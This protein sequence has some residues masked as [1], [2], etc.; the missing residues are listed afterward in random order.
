A[1]D[2]AEA[3]FTAGKKER[4]DVHD[5][6]RFRS[7]LLEE[8]RRVVARTRTLHARPPRENPSADAHAYRDAKACRYAGSSPHAC[9]A[10]RA[11]SWNRR[12]GNVG[13]ARPRTRLT[14]RATTSFFRA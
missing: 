4:D 8:R 13:N 6:T 10:P 14:P 5:A 1:E 12:F 11:P 3:T 9:T 7:L 2:A